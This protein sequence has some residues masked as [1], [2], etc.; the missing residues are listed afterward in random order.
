MKIA[1]FVSRHEPTTEQTAIA[2]AQGYT[3][4]PVGD[5]DAFDPNL[6]DLI[7]LMATVAHP[8]CDCIICVHPL[9][10]L[11]AYKCGFSV[12]VFE[13]ANRAP[14]G[15]KPSFQAVSLRIVEVAA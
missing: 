1:T 7:R 3:L 6:D 9:I 8:D 5:V 12:G 10:A 15:E 2:A 13:N 14:E 11:T 4:F